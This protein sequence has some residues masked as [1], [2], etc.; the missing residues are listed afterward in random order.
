[1]LKNLFYIAI[2]TL[3][4]QMTQAETAEE[5]RELEVEIERATEALENAARRLSELHVGRDWKDQKGG[6]RAML[7]IL[8]GPKPSIGGVAIVGT[9]PKGGAAQAGLVAGDLIVEIGGVDLRDSNDPLGALSMHMKSVNAGDTVSVVV[10]RDEGDEALEIVTQAK[11]EHI[12]SLLDDD[13]NYIIA[14]SLDDI[15]INVQIPDGF[16]F[17]YKDLNQFSQ[18]ITLIKGSSNQIMY[19][20]GDLAEYFDVDKGVVVTGVMRGSQLKNGDV[21]VALGDID[22]ENFDAVN[23]ALVGLEED[24]VARIKR[25][26]ENREVVIKPGEFTPGL[27]TEVKVI[28]SH[29]GSKP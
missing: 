27:D 22:V 11:S 20:E 15:D 18:N 3:C 6:K 8:L 17:D 7:G 19:V 23:D 9:T 21:F 1:M 10:A 12:M 26:G 29:S 25:Q 4:A 16:K 14:Q 2:F 28:R 5:I 24:L 13:L